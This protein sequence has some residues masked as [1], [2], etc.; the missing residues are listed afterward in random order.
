MPPVFV[1]LFCSLP[2]FQKPNCKLRCCPPINVLTIQLRTQE[3]SAQN[4][5]TKQREVMVEEGEEEE[6]KG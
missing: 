2:R 4:L 3:E 1:R 6:E 5:M